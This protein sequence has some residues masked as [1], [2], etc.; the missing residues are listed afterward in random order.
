MTSRPTSDVALFEQ[1]PGDGES[2]LRPMCAGR[3]RDVGTTRVGVGETV[4]DHRGCQAQ[5][6]PVRAPTDLHKVKADQVVRSF[7]PVQPACDLFDHPGVAER[8]EPMLGQ[9]SGDSLTEG[10]DI[11][12]PTG[13][14]RCRLMPP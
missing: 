8:V 6:G 2:D 12:K 4:A 9:T 3:D 14:Q 1:M 11:W 7:A 5:R 10:E 13:W